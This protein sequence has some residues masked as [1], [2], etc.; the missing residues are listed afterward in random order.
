[1]RVN[2]DFYEMTGK[3]YGDVEASL[4]FMVNP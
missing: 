3:M 2:V 4:W 1:L